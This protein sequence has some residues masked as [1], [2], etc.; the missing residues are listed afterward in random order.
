MSAE[1]DGA[2]GRPIAEPQRVVLER[3][4][5]RPDDESLAGSNELEQSRG[6]KEKHR[7]GRGPVASPHADFAREVDEAPHPNEVA[8]R[9]THHARGTGFRSVRA[10]AYAIR[11]DHRASTTIPQNA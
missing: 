1:H 5:P 10:P 2:F 9:G 6:R 3:L 4:I 8:Q 7:A 11:R